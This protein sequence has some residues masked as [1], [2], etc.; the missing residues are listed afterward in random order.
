MSTDPK[1]IIQVQ[2]RCLAC[3]VH[4]F[5]V[6]HRTFP[7]LQVE[8]LSADSAAE[9][10]VNRLTAALDGA[11]DSSERQQIETALA[12]AQHFVAHEA[13]NLPHVRPKPTPF[14]ISEVVSALPD[15]SDP[16]DSTSRLLAKSSALELRRLTL[17]RGQEIPTHSARGTITVL[18]LSGR[19]AFSACDATR[20]LGPG[21]V[22]VLA[23][24]EPHS[25]LGLED[26]I[27]LLTKL[28]P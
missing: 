23:A 22:L 15:S 13:S 25:V 4:T 18:C 28:A 19:I 16:N 3:D 11:R 20:E 17:S 14:R 8:G 9:H 6:H 26:S 27:V 21:Q 7:E 5:L 2:T 24:G 12:E 1:P 10:L